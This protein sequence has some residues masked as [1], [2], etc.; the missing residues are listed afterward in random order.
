MGCAFRTVCAILQ[1]CG[2]HSCLE[3]NSKKFLSSLRPPHSPS[4]CVGGA[5]FWTRGR[6]NVTGTTAKENQGCQVL[7]KEEKRQMKKKTFLA[8]Y[9]IF[10]MAAFVDSSKVKCQLDAKR[11]FCILKIAKLLLSW[12]SKKAGWQRCLWKC[13]SPPLS[14]LFKSLDCSK[15]PNRFLRKARCLLSFFFLFGIKECRLATL[16]ELE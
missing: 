16:P 13:P 6:K 5:I 10:D 4:G 12:P 11:L 3:E 14:L 8:R 2:K 1:S 15:M 9:A 7:W